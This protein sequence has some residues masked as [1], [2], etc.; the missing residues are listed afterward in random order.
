MLIHYR[1]SPLSFDQQLH[2]LEEKGLVVYDKQSALD[3]L[4]CIS[5]ERFKAYLAPFKSRESCGMLKPNT[6]FD[7]VYD[8]YE[9]DRELRL[10]VMDAIEWVEVAIRT[11]LTYHIAHKYGIFAHEEYEFFQKR[12]R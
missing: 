4:S 9:L 7:D 8:L 12:K 6:T 5:Y 3:V 10:L 2:L 1:K 11:Q